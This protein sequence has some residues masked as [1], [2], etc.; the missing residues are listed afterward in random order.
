MI[1]RGTFKR[2]LDTLD[3]SKEYGGDGHVVINIGIGIQMKSIH[4]RLNSF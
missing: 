2:A 4:E 1:V 3:L